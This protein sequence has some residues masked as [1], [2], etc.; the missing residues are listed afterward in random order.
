MSVSALVLNR[1][2][3]NIGWIGQLGEL[4]R[5]DRDKEVSKKEFTLLEIDFSRSVLDSKVFTWDRKTFGML[6]KDDRLIL[7][8]VLGDGHG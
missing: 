6:H 1:A 5:V 8:G 4:T 2:L 7:V 3:L